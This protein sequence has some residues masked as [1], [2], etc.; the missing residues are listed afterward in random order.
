[1]RAFARSNPML[2]F[3]R[4]PM[5]ALIALGA[6]GCGNPTAASGPTTPTLVAVNPA[7]FRGDVPCTDAPG[8]MRSF[9]ATIFDLGSLEEPHDPFPLPSGVVN[10]GTGTYRP[11]RCET[12]A[13]FS[14]VIPGHRYD[15]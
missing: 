2:F 12:P 10:D 14:F 4:R 5:A 9:V 3:G 11:A 6:I 8:A 7:D 15:A 13:G 1:M